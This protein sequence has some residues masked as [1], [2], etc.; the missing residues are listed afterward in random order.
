MKIGLLDFKFEKMSRSNLP[1]YISVKETESLI[2][3]CT[4]QL[5]SDYPRYGGK[6]VQVL[7]VLK[8]F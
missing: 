4:K 2:K 6:L 8:L 3:K 7:S 1:K 5:L